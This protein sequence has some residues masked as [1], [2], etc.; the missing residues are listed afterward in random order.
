MT[1]R[2]TGAGLA[3]GSTT[4]SR[5]ANS[6]PS[7]TGAIQ[8]PGSMVGGWPTAAAPGRPVRLSGTRMTA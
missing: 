3:R 2:S 4:H 8:A 6:P 7:T 5:P 1:L